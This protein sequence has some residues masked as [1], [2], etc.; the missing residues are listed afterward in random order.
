[1]LV[2]DVI[3][4]SLLLGLIFGLPCFEVLYNYYYYVERSDNMCEAENNVHMSIL[5]LDKISYGISE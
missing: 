2:G 3:F 4:S 1:M 5:L